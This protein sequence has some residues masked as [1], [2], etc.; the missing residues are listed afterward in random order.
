MVA[1]KEEYSVLP[2][3]KKYWSDLVKRETVEICGMRRELNCWCELGHG[4][5]IVLVSAVIAA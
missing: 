4:F 5:L 3:V 1:E 2:V